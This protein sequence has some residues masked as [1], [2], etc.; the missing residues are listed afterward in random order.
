[1]LDKSVAERVSKFIDSL[2]SSVYKVRVK[3]KK[4]GEEDPA[5]NIP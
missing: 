4:A 1:M 3:R 5:T 2:V